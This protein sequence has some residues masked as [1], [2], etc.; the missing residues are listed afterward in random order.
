M[1][2]WVFHRFLASLNYRSPTFLDLRIDNSARKIF[3][4]FI[5]SVLFTTLS[6]GF[7]ESMQLPFLKFQ[8]STL[9]EGQI[10]KNK[11]K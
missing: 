3:I 10:A 6:S 5:K 8:L 9:K 2:C 7:R 1:I 11:Q 4:N